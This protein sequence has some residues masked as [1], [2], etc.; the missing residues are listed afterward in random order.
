MRGTI[1]K[2]VHLSTQSNIPSAEIV[3]D[4]N[5]HGY[6][7]IETPEAEEIYFDHGAVGGLGFDHLS[8]GDSVRFELDEAEPKLAASVV[9]TE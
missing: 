9:R 2:L 4:H 6:G 7:Y 8:E 1:K 3:R 5:F